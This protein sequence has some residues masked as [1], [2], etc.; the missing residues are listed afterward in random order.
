MTE[1]P[2]TDAEIEGALD[3]LPARYRETVRA[4]LLLCRA[5]QRA[6]KALREIAKAEQTSSPR[7]ADIS[8]FSDEWC[9]GFTAGENGA[10]GALATIARDAL[11]REE[12]DRG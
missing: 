7:W 2:L 10:A 6:E 4:I 5:L 3:I 12:P 1:Q 8:D 11:P 9:A